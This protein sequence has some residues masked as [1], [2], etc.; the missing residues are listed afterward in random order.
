MNWFVLE[1]TTSEGK[2][3]DAQV[4]KRSRGQD[5]SLVVAGTGEHGRSTLAEIDEYTTF[6]NHGIERA[7]IEES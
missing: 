6:L 2:I 7:R 5:P 1:E 3:H 4:G